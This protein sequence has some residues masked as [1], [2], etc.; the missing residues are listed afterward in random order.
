MNSS[1]YF[2]C[3]L[4]HEVSVYRNESVFLVNFQDYVFFRAG[5]FLSD[6]GTDVRSKGQF[7]APF[8]T[9]WR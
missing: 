6:N 5:G 7:S 2:K 3:F 1:V 9:G 8:G 4:E